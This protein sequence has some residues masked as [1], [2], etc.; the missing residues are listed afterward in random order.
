MYT[1]RAPAAQAAGFARSGFDVVSL[2]PSGAM[3]EAQMVLSPAE[4]DSLHARGYDI[5]VTKDKQGRS[6]AQR[7]AAQAASGYTVYR[8]WDEPGGIRDELHAVAAQNPQLV[9]LEVLGH[10]YQGRELLA[11]KVTQGARGTPDG[12]RPAVLYSATQHAREWISTEVDRRLLHYFIDRWR[13]NDKTIKNLLKNTELWFV[14]VA[15]PDGYQYTFDHERLWRKNLRD[16]NGDGQITGVDGVD[17]NRNFNEH[18]NYDN[19][20]SSTLTSS[21]TYRGPAP[22]SEPETRAMQGLLNRIKPKLQSNFHSFGPYI[23]F[24]QGWQVGTPDA[25]NPIYTALGGT[26]AHPAIAGFDPGISAEELYV[27]NGETTDYADVNAGTIAITPELEEGCEGCGFVFPDDEGLI[28]AE[29]EKTLPFSLDMAK[30]AANP[31]SPVSH[32]GNT[33]K[34]FYLSQTEVD[35]ENGALAMFDFR[36]AKSY[37][38]PQEVRVLAKKS[39]GAVTLKYQINGGAIQSRSTS[40]WIG[41]ERYGPGR[42][43]YYRVMSGTITGTAPGD[44]VK[45]WFTGGGQSSD[46]F[47]YTVA[48]D[49]GRRVLVMAAEDYTGASP[50]QGVTSPKYLAYYTD[51]LTANGIAYDVYDV[52]ANGRTAPDA[53]GVLSHYDAVIWYT[54]DDTVTREPG[55]LA[56]NASRLAIQELYEVRDYL[57]EGGKVFYTGKN[58]GAQ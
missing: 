5:A 2:K 48:L 49:T 33:V 36:F 29:F 7:A 34:P 51:S 39:L 19:E 16:N 27:T 12:T 30:T 47:T 25:D 40:V 4:R 32:L 13:A 24:P 41:G 45:V 18:W 42:D 22:A 58:A 20:G 3:T 11:L 38:D 53:L 15:N 37:G 21:D 44:S 52:D 23:L 28:Q 43:I 26:D 50:V 6:E 9:K 46:S 35:A 14:V 56:G 1:V 31:G 17:P 55:W 8:S 54:G 10:T 57:N